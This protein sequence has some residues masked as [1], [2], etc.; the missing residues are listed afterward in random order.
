MVGMFI[1]GII[2]ELKYSSY[3]RKNKQSGCVFC[4]DDAFDK[5]RKI[6]QI[7]N[8]MMVIEND[9][10]YKRWANQP[11]AS[12][13]MIVPKRH[14]LKIADLTDDESADLAQLMAAY[15]EQ[16][17]SFYIRSF[18]DK[19]RSVAHIHGHLFSYK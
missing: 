9:F 10:P 17:Y 15:D 14:V 4:Y 12:H 6:V 1:R 5:N 18:A 16:N 2:G 19:Y 8:T 11:V 3:R 7:T 13:L